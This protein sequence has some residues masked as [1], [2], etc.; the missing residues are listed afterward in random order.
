MS[1]GSPDRFFLDNIPLDLRDSAFGFVTHAYW[2]SAFAFSHKRIP[3]RRKLMVRRGV[4]V[5]CSASYLHHIFLLS[6]GV[7]GP[8]RVGRFTQS[9]DWSKISDL[10][11]MR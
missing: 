10:L 1:G 7:P 9:G 4:H 5:A 6:Q 3:G 11:A 2:H 8:L